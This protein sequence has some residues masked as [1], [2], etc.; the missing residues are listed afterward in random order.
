M[1][2]TRPRKLSLHNDC[3]KALSY[4]VV[5]NHWLPAAE[6]PSAQGG[7]AVHHPLGLPW[8]QHLDTSTGGAHRSG[9]RETSENVVVDINHQHLSYQGDHGTRLGS[10]WKY[11]APKERL[12]SS[13]PAGSVLPNTVASA[14]FL[15]HHSDVRPFEQSVLWGWGCF[16]LQASTWIVWDYS[17]QRE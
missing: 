3:R 5:E 1:S 6:L 10:I 14:P 16:L 13:V 12:K 17:I 11:Q 2:C 8:Q 4:S 15:P 7:C 9:A